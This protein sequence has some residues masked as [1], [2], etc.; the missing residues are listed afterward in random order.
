MLSIADS[1][2]DFLQVPFA[3]K[4][5]TTN[6]RFPKTINFAEFCTTLCTSFG[7]PQARSALRHDGAE[8]MFG[9]LFVH[10]VLDGNLLQKWSPWML[11]ELQKE[12]LTSNETKDEIKR[13][14]ETQQR[15]A[16]K[17]SLAM[18]KIK[19]ESKTN[20]TKCG[21]KEPRTKTLLDKTNRNEEINQEGDKN[22]KLDKKG[23]ENKRRNR[24]MTP[25]K[26]CS[27]LN[28]ILV[29][30]LADNHL[31][32]K[33]GS[34][35]AQKALEKHHTGTM[36][37][38]ARVTK[39]KKWSKTNWRRVWS[40]WRTGYLYPDWITEYEN[41]NK[42][43]TRMMTTCAD[44]A[45]EYWEASP[46]DACPELMEAR[47]LLIESLK[48]PVKFDQE[49]PEKKIDISK[50]VFEKQLEGK[51]DEEFNSD[52]DKESDDDARTL[53]SVGV[54]GPMETDEEC[55]LA[56]TRAI[57]K[58]VDKMEKNADNC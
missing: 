51:S 32:L 41:Q 6:I 31:L 44:A 50:T 4:G 38:I 57:N 9:T 34:V 55:Q 28:K 7:I 48:E 1:S 56:V 45:Y 49:K 37:K 13:K 52:P 19:Q 25:S 14:E 10:N 47:R 8:I 12:E 20:K 17:D 58:L 15:P 43:R 26:L 3:Y 40:L 29:P 39:T 16:T 21:N 23:G 27:A 35:L 18:D 24:T 22:A 54:T 5:A 11:K 30:L 42:H 46:G 53:A 33:D 36:E 2:Q